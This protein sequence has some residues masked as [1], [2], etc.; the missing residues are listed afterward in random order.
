[1]AELKTKENS[2]D[3]EAFLDAAAKGQKRLDCDAISKLMKRLTQC[4]PKMW[5]SSIVGFGSY[6]YTYASGHEGDAPLIGFSPRKANISLYL[7]CGLTADKAL[8][9]K[10]GKHKMGKGCLYINSVADVDAKVLEQIIK[11]SLDGLQKQIAANKKS[12][13]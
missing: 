9:E 10:L 1:M 8:F 7:L 2:G 4:E 11:A 13:K 6:H 3:V 5:G 12:A